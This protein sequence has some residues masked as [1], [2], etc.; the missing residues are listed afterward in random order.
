MPWQLLTQLMACG[1]LLASDQVTRMDV[2][3]AGEGGY[4]TFR[5]P[6][7]VA[8]GGPTSGS[9]ILLLFAEGRKFSSA[10]HDWNDIML[11]RSLDGGESWGPLQ[12]VWSEST[13]D[14]HVTIG[15]PTPVS[16]QNG[17]VLLLFTRNN[18][19]VGR[20]ASAD[21]G[22]SWPH[23]PVYFPVVL[24][25]VPPSAANATLSHIAT[26]P[27]SGIELRGSSGEGHSR[28]VG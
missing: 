4:H 22:A 9:E 11:K 1:S 7:M 21:G 8:T 16:L 19:E 2:F 18:L 10:D 5:I 12:C 20:M 6:S 26:G 27:T 24:P 13:A 17:T 25:A 23:A 3:T 15:N 28:L 14:V